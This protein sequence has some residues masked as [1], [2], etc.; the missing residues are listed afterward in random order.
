MWSGAGAYEI[1][2][3]SGKG[4]AK[5]FVNKSIGR[6]RSSM[7]KMQA[8]LLRNGGCNGGVDWAARISVARLA[9]TVIMTD[10]T[11]AALVE[12]KEIGKQVY[13]AVREEY[14]GE[15]FDALP[16]VRYDGEIMDDDEDDQIS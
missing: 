14:G 10:G 1:S 4:E 5:A 9:G 15:V 16:E 6:M 8:V 13:V 3:Q 2:D 7:S 11:S 12:Q